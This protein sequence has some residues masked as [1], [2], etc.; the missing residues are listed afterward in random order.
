MGVVVS[1]SIEILLLSRE[2]AI[3][4][5]LEVPTSSCPQSRPVLA[6][7]PLSLPALFSLS[8]HED[9][10]L[11]I[12][13]SLYRPPSFHHSPIPILRTNVPRR[14]P[15]SATPTTA[16]RRQRFR[17]V[18]TNIRVRYLPL[19]LSSILCLSPTPFLPSPSPTPKFY[20]LANTAANSPLHKLPLPLHPRLRPF[21]APLP[22][23]VPGRRR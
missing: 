4:A 18:S 17:M 16:K 6:S 20:L 9:D 12:P 7:T 13:P 5:N 8:Q 22:M 19:S 15:A 21:P 1:S 14:P 2:T 10:T 11:S 3:R 23:P